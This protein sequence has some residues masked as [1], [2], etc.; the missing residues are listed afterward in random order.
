MGLEILGESRRNF[1]LYFC[2]I[3]SIVMFFFA[4]PILFP[5]FNNAAQNGS[6]TDFFTHFIGLG[7]GIAVSDFYF[8]SIYILKK[9][10]PSDISHNL[11]QNT[12]LK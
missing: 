12:K 9:K 6:F 4:P 8:T 3:F 1:V 7:L 5:S 2:L 10:K 11:H